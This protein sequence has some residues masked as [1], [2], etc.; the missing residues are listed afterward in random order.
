[1]L[2]IALLERP[3]V[4]STHPRSVHPP[5][6]QAQIRFLRDLQRILEEGRVTAS[7]KF[8]LVH[9]LADLSVQKGD[10]SGA[11]LPLR[12]R[13]I[14]VRFIELYGPQVAPWPSPGTPAPLAQNTGREAAVV[15][16]ARASSG[17]IVAWVATGAVR[18]RGCGG[19]GKWSPGLC[20]RRGW[21]YQLDQTASAIARSSA[22]RPFLGRSKTSSFPAMTAP[23]TR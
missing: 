17:T 6:A 13:D 16:E 9:A 5:S 23:L 22:N 7:Y 3:S 20:G 11:P 4:R 15:R 19:R 10:D 1:M 21:T 8:A 18:L 12:V 2:D 14:A